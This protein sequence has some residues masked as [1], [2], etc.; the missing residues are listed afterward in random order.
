MIQ[1]KKRL[2]A[3]IMF[4]DMVG[5]T[6]L[7]QQNEELAKKNRDKHREILQNLISEHAGKILQYYGDGT[8]CIF[9]SA[10]EAV[11]CATKI[12]TE[13][14]KDPPIPLRIGI[15]SG[16][17]VYDDEGVYGDAVNVASRIEN[18][19]I[20]GSVLISKK[21]MNELENHPELTTKTLGQ[22]NLKN[23]KQPVEIYAVT[24]GN[25][26]VPT[27][28]QIKI[29][30]QEE[31]KS[32]AVLPFVNMSPDPENEYFSD[33]IT[34]ELLNA[35]TRVEGLQVTAR[36]SSFA[37]KGR[38]Q[39]IRQ[40]GKQLGVKSVLEGSVRKAGNKVR[41]TAQL[42]NSADGYHIWSETYD[43]ELDDIFAIQD[44]ISLKITN[45]LKENLI[46]DSSTI[47]FVTPATSNIE[48]YNI[49][50]KGLF[51]SH[52]WTLDDNERAIEYFQKAI[53][54]D[55]NFALAYTGIARCYGFLGASGKYA[56]SQ[57]FPRSE[58]YA[59][60]AYQLDKNLSES[61]FAL[62][63]VNFWYHWDWDKTI[64][65]INKAIELNPDSA[66]AYQFKA[67]IMVAFGDNEAA[68]LLIKKSLLL[69]PLN[70]PSYYCSATIYFYSDMV[71]E[72]FSQV[73]KALELAPFFP[74][75]FFLKGLIHQLK[76]E[77]DRA[78]VLFEKMRHI[79][80]SEERAISCLGI[81]YALQKKMDLAN[82][83][84]NTLLEIEK[85]E[86]EKSVYFN[87]ACQYFAL[88]DLQ[89]MFV[90][91][92]KAIERKDSMI[93]YFF[94]HPQFKNLRSDPRF[95]RLLHMMK[96]DDMFKYNNIA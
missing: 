22:F 4:T 82:N 64:Y 17:I 85:N 2:L 21:V 9:E 18:L 78:E 10:I 67:M 66:D 32:I 60:K 52:K 55:P 7:M 53:D 62:T 23:V 73:N 20:A 26:I 8:L 14:Q 39:D 3:A 46:H 51:H 63:S 93:I 83:N 1:N 47:S 92:E 58:E 12:Q 27:P 56:P 24:S 49:Y 69:D 71:D 40:I 88:G 61:Y 31:K 95:K 89:K 25:T 86:P 87:L 48:A 84:L 36:T 90:Y 65:Y 5:Y 72:A 44:E 57:A 15:H 45:R 75:A 81:N 11:K 35:L 37:F 13:L 76:G 77:F 74:D 19:S 16:D 33:G 91:L 54:I 59:Q 6:A 80:G 96:M 41:I 38:D 94:S 79:P 68:V 34:E 42:I 30:P 29:K 43:R 28:E 50:L 70:A